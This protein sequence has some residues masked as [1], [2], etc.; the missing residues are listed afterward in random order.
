LRARE[1]EAKVMV[2]GQ[3]A[4]RWMRGRGIGGGTVASGSGITDVGSLGLLLDEIR[5]ETLELAA[6]VAF[7]R[8]DDGSAD[9]IRALKVSNKA[10][11]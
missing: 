5:D 4:E 3:R 6:R 1:D 10:A 2:N 8:G 11:P 7:R 9:A